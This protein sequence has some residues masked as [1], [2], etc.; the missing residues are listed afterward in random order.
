MEMHIDIYDN[1]DKKQFQV[2]IGKR[3]NLYEQIEM[4]YKNNPNMKF[5]PNIEKLKK[6][7]P[8][9]TKPVLTASRTVSA[10]SK[11]KPSY[12][13]STSSIGAKSTAAKTAP[14]ITG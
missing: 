5:V 7:M 10:T 14:A 11:I 8:V 9:P 2:W 3:E 1:N 13:K 4:A 12:V 6:N